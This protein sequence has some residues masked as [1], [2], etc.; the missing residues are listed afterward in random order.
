[1]ITAAALFSGDL[2]SA[3]RAMRSLVL[4]GQRRLHFT[5]ESDGRRKRILDAITELG[6]KVTIYDASAHHRRRQR[7][8]CLDALV[9]NLASIGTRM[10]VLES[11]ESIVELDRKTLYRSVRRHGCHEILEY[12][13]L[14]AFEEPLLAVPDALAWCWQRGGHWKTR[15]RE[16]VEEI[17]TV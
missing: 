2:A 15:V 8:A 14:R 3:R 9:E 10:L 1:M 4:P 7:E 12:R 17:R 5:H 16:M 6:P 11:D 13:H